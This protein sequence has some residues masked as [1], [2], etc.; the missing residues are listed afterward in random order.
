MPQDRREEEDRYAHGRESR[1]PAGI[2]FGVNDDL[3]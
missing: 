3:F 2:G 1:N